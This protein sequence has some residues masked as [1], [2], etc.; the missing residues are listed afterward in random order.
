MFIKKQLLSVTLL[1]VVSVV[2]A[3][4]LTYDLPASAAGRKVCN[5]PD[6]GERIKCKFDNVNSEMSDTVDYLTDPDVDFLT[7]E[8]KDH[9]KHA[10]DRTLKKTGNIPEKDFKKLSKKR[11]A[12]CEIQEILGDV[13]PRNDT[14]GNEEC[15][16][17]EICIGD[18]DGICSPDEMAH[19]GCAEV[20]NDGIGDDDGIC[21][22][23]GKYDEACVEICDPDSIIG[24]QG[25]VDNEESFDVEESLDD[26]TDLFDEVNPSIA[27]FVEYMATQKALVSA[28]GNSASACTSL[29]VN[30]R[31]FDFITLQGTL[32]GANAAKLAADSCRDACTQTSFGWNCRAV[33]LCFGL[34]ENVLAEISAAF[35][36]QDDTVTA[37]RVDAAV[38]CLEELGSK[39][40]G[41]DKKIDSVINLLNTPE[42]QRPHFPLK[43]GDIDW[44]GIKDGADNCVYIYNPDQSDSNG[45]G[46]G[47]ACDL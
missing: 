45:N 28:A 16:E 24:K 46:I 11:D 5:Q 40:D 6:S 10:R 18:E 17:L 43:S 33:C 1:E 12:E 22:T 9:L 42:G 23:K 7:P 41:I 30:T 13:E 35:E 37:E 39:I 19:G 31:Q 26:V 21:E 3:L 2:F 36:L 27:N 47:D 34:A 29:L 20:L 8:Q 25:N 14:N 32:A 38:L 15:D 4:I 44:D